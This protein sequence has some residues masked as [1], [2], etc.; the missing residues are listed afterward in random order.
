MF[1]AARWKRL[2]PLLIFFAVYT[3]LFLL[4]VKT[5]FYSLPFVAGFLVAL[6]LQPLARWLQKRFRLRQGVAA[7]VSTAVALVVL[8]GGLALLG[9][10]AVREITA[11]LRRASENGFEEFSKPVA[12][13]LNQAG[14]F[15]GK[16]DLSFFENHQQEILDTLQNSMD[17]LVSGLGALLQLLTSVP[18]V[19]T[20][21]LV[22]VCSAFF[23]T[24]DMR[25]ILHWGKAFFS[26]K[27]ASHM[28]AAVKST[29]GNGRKYLLSYL[30]LY[31]LTFCQTFVILAVLGIPYPLM[32]SMATAIADVLPVLGPGLVLAPV[33]IYQLLTGHYARALGVG[34]GWLVITCIRQV[35]EPKLVSSTVKV[36]PLATLA[37]VYFSLVGRNIW[38]LFYVLGLC[39]LYGA[40]RDTGALP[41][42]VETD[43]ENASDS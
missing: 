41:S 30:F 38:I 7:G 23:F 31:F 10:I 4:W 17:L 34:I 9:M 42:L 39:T 22:T 1:Q 3:L 18:M 25:S 24:R 28:T 37:A 32:F 2:L 11:F 43:R 35:V 20:L 26:D 8:C 21:L 16:F 5:F 27:A 15:F 6:I 36:H 13:F 12:D 33:A 14:S 40:F 29:G 19:V